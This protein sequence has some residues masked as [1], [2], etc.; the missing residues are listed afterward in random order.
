MICKQ[1]T[2]GSYTMVIYKEGTAA[3]NDNK[4]RILE[5]V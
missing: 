4:E 5:E 2:T 3:K 1:L